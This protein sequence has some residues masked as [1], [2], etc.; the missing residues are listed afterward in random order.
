MS[1]NKKLYMDDTHKELEIAMA[2]KCWTEREHRGI[3]ECSTEAFQ[4]ETIRLSL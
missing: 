3:S 4:Q 1:G 2:E